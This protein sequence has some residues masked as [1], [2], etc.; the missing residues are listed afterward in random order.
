MKI[1]FFSYPFGYAEPPKIGSLAIIAYQLGLRLAAANNEVLFYASKIPHR[2][3]LEYSEDGI[4]YRG[5]P[6]FFPDK[7]ISTLLEK[8]DEWKISHPL[9]P[10][11]TS[12]LYY[13][14][15]YWQVAKNLK[16]KKCEVVHIIDVSQAVTLVRFLNPQAKIVL[17]AETEWLSYYDQAMIEKRVNQADLVIGC[18]DYVTDRIRKRF[19]QLKSAT[20]YNGVDTNY[21]IPP[22]EPKKSS[23]TG[24]KQILYIGRISPEKGI[25]VLL[26]AFNQV[27][28]HYP[29]VQ[30]V[31]IGP[32]TAVL[33]L[34]MMNQ[35][36][37]KVQEL[38]PFCQGE[39]LAQL[40]NIISPSA[41]DSV[42]FLGAVNYQD[43]IKYYQETD[44]FVFPSVWNEPFGMPIV[45][46]MSVELPVVATHGGA[47]PELVDEGKT[48]LLVERGNAE[49]LAE[50]ML[51]LLKD[52]NLCQEMGK[53][54]RKKVIEN[55]T[56]ECISEKLFNLYQDL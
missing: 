52:E 48:G 34:E 33:Q 42:S 7:I 3:E 26:E 9:R 54:G 24:V 30:L 49:A 32:E 25:H 39:Y 56:W 2:Q 40:K 14:G 22:T 31:L 47:F 6:E 41:A 44:I 5:I 35:E 15:F 43:L 37:P 27:L 46:A 36:D 16:A 19:P 29:Q 45:E 28:A 53:A 11:F 38:A 55:F 21:F 50:A 51:C 8:L 18:S 13:F 10:F 4:T 1:A 20:I 17:H 12:I 23:Q